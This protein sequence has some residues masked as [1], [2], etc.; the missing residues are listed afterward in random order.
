MRDIEGFQLN[1]FILQSA[2]F[3]DSTFEID[4]QVLAEVSEF[5]FNGSSAESVG[6]FWF[7]KVS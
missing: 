6:E 3:S 2:K 1:D 4:P 5:Y 7:G